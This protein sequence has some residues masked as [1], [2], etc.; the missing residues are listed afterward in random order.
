MML[1]PLAKTSRALA[2]T[3]PID[4]EHLSGRFGLLT[5]IVL[6]GSFVKILGYLSGPEYSL[7]SIG[8]ARGFGV[9]LVTFSVWWIYFDDV[10]GAE[11]KEER[12]AWMPWF[13]GHL[14]LACGITAVGV[15]LKKAISFDRAL[16]APE[17]YRALL[18][19]GL[20]CTVVAVAILDSVT[21][22]KEAA[23]SDRMRVN[24]RV[25]SAIMIGI[26]GAGGGRMSAL[27]YLSLISVFC[28]G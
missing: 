22:G 9:L 19:I 23:L 26:V 25:F 11:L 17:E 24:V 8:L 27:M 5:I 16:P 7:E 4:W 28:L 2:E 10:A 3:Y 15:G 12:G 18:T 6:G 13:Y 20:V 21:L 14:P 1:A